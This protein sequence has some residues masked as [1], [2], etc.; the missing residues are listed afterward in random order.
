MQRT[1]FD[2]AS[3]HVV[4]IYVDA[5][6]ANF[7]FTFCLILSVGNCTARILFISRFLSVFV[8]ENVLIWIQGEF[9]TLWGRAYT[10]DS[11]QC[12]S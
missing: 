1:H 5:T 2:V 11:G 9:N 12:H 8:D 3:S 7:D 6:V 10:V 4:K